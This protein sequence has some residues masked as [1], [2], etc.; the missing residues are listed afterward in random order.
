MNDSTYNIVGEVLRVEKVPNPRNFNRTTTTNVTVEDKSADFYF[1]E[2]PA[3]I[4]KVVV[5]TRIT[6]TAE[7]RKDSV[8][9]KHFYFK[10]ARNA[11]VEVD[12]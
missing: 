2:F 3:G 5:G 9:E 12:A 6:F 1:G 7:V 8:I 11:A 10:N 4:P